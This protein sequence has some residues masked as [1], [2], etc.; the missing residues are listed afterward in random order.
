MRAK[1]AFLELLEHHLESCLNEYDLCIKNHYRNLENYRE[2]RDMKVK[3]LRS[4]FHQNLNRLSEEFHRERRQIEREHQD[5]KE[6][7]EHMMKKIDKEERIKGKIINDMFQQEKEDIKDKNN[8]LMELMVTDMNSKKVNIHNALEHLFQKFMKDS[9]DKYRKFITYKTENHEDTTMIG[10]TNRRM[11]RV[12]EKIQFTS[13]KIMQMEREFQSKN[14]LIKKENGAIAKNFLELKNKMFNFR[15]KQHRKLTKLVS[16]SRDVQDKL[17]NL[18]DLIERI[19]KTA[20]FCRKLETKAERVLP[21]SGILPSTWS[22]LAKGLQE[23]N[24]GKDFK[25]INQKKILKFEVLKNF[26]EKYNKV[27]LDKKYLDTENE[28]L[29]KENDLLKEKAVQLLDK[30]SIPLNENNMSQNMIIKSKKLF[31]DNPIK[32][33]R[34]KTS[35]QNNQVVL[36]ENILARP[37]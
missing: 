21:F 14:T 6:N 32:S 37:N 4:N 29:R 9:K 8:D 24:L 33:I 10:E 34:V 36:N 15:N 16:S 19:L 28:K 25:F 22:D 13:L 12:K 27:L 20:E 26:L 7:L 2:L 11:L 35:V 1:E 17:Q 18:K 30:K 23:M 31:T 3:T 5:Q